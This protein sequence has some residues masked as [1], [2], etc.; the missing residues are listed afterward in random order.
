M[1]ASA[2]L[3]AAVA[4][5]GDT[6]SGSPHKGVQPVL[7]ALGPLVA[8]HLPGPTGE[9][10]ETLVGQLQAASQCQEY[11]NVARSLQ[12]AK[13]LGLPGLGPDLI[14][15]LVAQLGQACK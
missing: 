9:K 8:R 11:A 1:L 15:A 12:A 5:S 7:A 2:A 13:P 10:I 3:L 6:V 14:D 4:L